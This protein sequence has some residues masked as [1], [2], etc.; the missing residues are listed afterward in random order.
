MSK[1]RP[2]EAR[3][4]S[5]FEI[6]K[7]SHPEQPRAAIASDPSY[8]VDHVIEPG[9]NWY[10]VYAGEQGS[11][12]VPLLGW[13][14]VQRENGPPEVVAILPPLSGAAP[15]L[16]LRGYVRGSQLGDRREGRY[17]TF[18]EIVDE[19]QKGR[20]NQNFPPSE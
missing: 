16:E 1:P 12:M 3:N 14:V 11:S 9:E 20:I 18:D 10:A 13:A 2:V 19:M 7:P 17:M 4:P 6:P 8:R 15:G 5:D